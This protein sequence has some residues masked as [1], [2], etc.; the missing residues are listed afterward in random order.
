MV[1]KQ[2][3]VKYI[4]IW[5]YIAYVLQ[6]NTQYGT[7]PYCFIPNLGSTSVLNASPY[8]GYTGHYLKRLCVGLRVTLCHF[9]KYI[10]VTKNFIVGTILHACKVV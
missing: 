4:V 5:Q 3:F 9:M 7:D 2:H 10:L 8:V 1:V 6:S